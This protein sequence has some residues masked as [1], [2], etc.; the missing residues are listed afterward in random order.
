MIPTYILSHSESSSVLSRNMV[1]FRG[2]SLDVSLVCPLNSVVRSNLG[3][4]TIKLGQ[5]EHHG[6]DS[7]WRMIA[8][9][10]LAACSPDPVLVMEYDCLI[11]PDFFDHALKDGEIM[12]GAIFHTDE[13]AYLAKAFPH[14]PY[15]AN[16]TTWRKV[17]QIG[18]NL[19]ENG[20]SD[21]W[22]GA[23]ADQ[24][25][26][27]LIPRTSVSFNSYET[28]EQ[29]EAAKRAISEGTFCCTHGVKSDR[30]FREITRAKTMEEAR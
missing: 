25:G 27:K 18:A 1:N 30:S 4:P 19:H 6:A 10:G 24:G 2:A 5:K 11:W 15:Y 9:A 13:K 7:I 12:C 23:V 17:V 14:F 3:L 16:A 29:I 26:L 22:M 8:L 21:R 28:D 20:M